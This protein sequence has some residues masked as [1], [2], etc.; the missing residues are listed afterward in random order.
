MAKKKNLIGQ[1]FTRLTVISQAPK[2]PKDTRA[3][4]ICQCSCE[5]KNI[6][7]LPTNKLTTQNN[8]SCGCLRTDSKSKEVKEKIGDATRIYPPHIASAR[9]RYLHYRRGDKYLNISFEEF[10]IISQLPCF[11]C[12][13]LPINSNCF[14]MFKR[15]P[16]ASNR[17]LK[18]GNFYHNGLDRIDSDGYHTDDNILPCCIICN[19]F[20]TYL[21]LEQTIKN[22]GRFTKPKIFNSPFE[23]KNIGLP[24]NNNIRSSFNS[25]YRCNNDKGK[26][27]LTKED[28]YYLNQQNCFYCDISP[29]NTTNAP[30]RDKKSSQKAKDE[31]DY[32]YNGI[33]RVNNKMGHMKNNIVP[34]CGN[35]NW[36]KSKITLNDFNVWIERIVNHYPTLIKNYQERISLMY[37]N[38]YSC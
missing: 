17:A 1:K 22:L 6:V 31:G 5:N 13:V 20:K 16:G 11:Y 9:R 37:Q 27:D 38:N 36:A 15:K 29:S 14:N 2:S 8:K 10:Y 3:Y 28:L 7:I 34:C 26:S 25:V 4:W 18:E 19:R 23:I 32:I 33:D 12:G 24:I 21:T 35:C 30:G